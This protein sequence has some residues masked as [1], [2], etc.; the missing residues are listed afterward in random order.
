[1]H[2]EQ[3]PKPTHG[4][5]S[6]QQLRHRNEQDKCVVGASEVATVMG[7]ND[8]E[9]IAD[10]AIRKLLP[11][12]TTET[13]EAMMRGNIL[14]PALLQYAQNM[15]DTPIITPDVMYRNGQ[16]IATLDGRGAE[17]TDLIVEVKTNNHWALGNALPLQWQWQAQA[18][19]YCT[20][21]EAVHF[22]VLDKNMRLGMDLVQRSDDMI[23][24]MLLHV[25]NFCD[26]IDT[27]CLPS[28]VVLTAPQI[29]QLHPVAVGEVELHST[30]LSLLAEWGAIKDAMKELDAKEQQCKDALANMLMDNEYGSV[31]GQRVLSYKTQ[32]TKR[33]DSK[34][35]LADS[36]ELAE[37]YTATSTFRVLRA[38]K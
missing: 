9:S 7:C 34:A 30:A 26:A 8:Y 3:L 10:I 35:L 16:I 21:T 13:N 4:T 27:Q 28:D 38:I 32:S 33:F 22:A 23:E 18:Q 6:W 31:N 37:K 1:M 19:M 15:L 12:Q 24:Q 11:P 25:A 29:A 17:Q 20:D 5:L 36:P 2:I 14:E